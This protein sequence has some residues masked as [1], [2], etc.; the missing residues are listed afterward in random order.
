ME[1]R[2]S[3]GI[4]I[5][6][7]LIILF[8]LSFYLEGVIY[9]VSKSMPLSFILQRIITNPLIPILQVVN[10]ICAIGILL[11]KDWAR[12]TFIFLC[13]VGLVLGIGALIFLMPIPLYNKMSLIIFDGAFLWFFTR[14]KVK[15]QFE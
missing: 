14:P 2:R 11:L 1:K 3:V 13:M 6:G 15:G 7:I 8:S 5:A 4:T 9:C 12:R 10:I